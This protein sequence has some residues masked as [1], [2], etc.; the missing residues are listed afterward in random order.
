MVSCQGQTDIVTNP[1]ER[2]WPFVNC[3]DQSTQKHRRS[4]P[5][6]FRGHA[7]QRWQWRSK[8]LSHHEW[9]TARD[10]THERVNFAPLLPIRI[11]FGKL[12]ELLGKAEMDSRTARG[13]DALAQRA[14]RGS[15]A[16]QRAD[17]GLGIKS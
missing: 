7:V 4:H 8:S 10:E 15:V 16:Q 12:F 11:F 13:S 1:V 2:R 9:L 3:C 6:R 5:L 14:G 17:A